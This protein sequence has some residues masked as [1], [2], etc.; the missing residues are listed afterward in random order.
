MCAKLSTRLA[1]IWRL[2]KPCKQ[3]FGFGLSK[4]VWIQALVFVQRN[5]GFSECVKG[6]VGIVES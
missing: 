2:H 6:S 5:L 1:C 4:R 3:E